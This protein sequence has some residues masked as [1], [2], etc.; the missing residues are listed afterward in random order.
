MIKNY[1]KTAFRSLMKNK[2]FTFINV[3]GLALGLATCL[4]IVFYVFDELSYDKYNLNADRIFRVDNNIKFGGDENSYAVVP[5]PTATALKNDYPEVEEV[6]RFRPRGGAKVKKGNENIQE[7]MMIYADSSIFKVFTLPMVSGDPAKAL[8]EPH[9]VVITESIAKKYFNTT[10]AAGKVLTF[11]DSSLYKVAGVIKDIPK[12]SHFN[13]DFFVSMAGRA[14]S[15]E[16]AW[17]SNNFNTYILLKPGTDY[18]K[19]EAKL[20]EFLRKHAGA[21]LQSILHLT[22]DKLEQGGNYFKFSLTPLKQIHLQSNRI[23][24]LAA[25]GNLEYVYIFSAIALFILLIACVNFMNLSTARSSNRAREVGVRKVLGSARKSLIMQFLTESVL[26]TLIST[27]IAV[28]GAWLLLPLFNQMA[29]KDL[30]VTAHIIAWL[31]PVLFVVVLVIGCLAG[32]YP[33]VFLSAFQPID[34]LKGKLASGFKGGMLRSFL[35]VFQFAIS[36]VLII[37]TLVIYNQLKFIQNTDLGYNRD[38]V[39]IINNLWT[40]NHGAKSFK[41]EVKQISGVENATLTGALPT[42]DYGNSSALFKDPVIDQKRS[43]ISQEWTVDVDYINTLGIKLKAGRNF[44]K[45]MPTDT[46]AVIINEAAA[47]MLG[48]AN[49]LNQM[50]YEPADNMVKKLNGYHIIGVIKNFN[51]KSLRNNVT[52][53]VL[54]LND[55]RGAL[56]IRIKSAN[57]PMVLSQ[58]KNLWKGR[59]PNQVLNYSF[60]DDDF[61]A[62]YRSERRT[63]K[64]AVVFTSLAILIA[65]LGLFGLA[66]Y[67]TEQRTKEIGIRK[68][69]GA[70]VSTIVGMLSKDFIL[71]VLVSIMVASP[72]AY[73][74]MYKWLQGFAYHQNIQWWI[75]AVAGIGAMLIAFVTISFQAIKAALTNPVKSLKSE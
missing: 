69:L 47:K 1:I 64:I 6:A 53:L 48:Y 3:F 67:A 14:D 41:N 29:D 60:M 71:L 37:G 57:V 7:N 75:I 56:S 61:D 28:F 35:V 15:R 8:T 5:S 51:F 22:F 59:S 24:E 32:L 39:L 58:V 23:S 44:S 21:Q 31:V 55:D 65:C 70:N 20:P 27:L 12:Q 2:G 4:L 66:A 26:I 25:N 42:A 46:T 11:N 72:F 34:V 17:F 18:K 62:L 45:D 16:D 33:A 38:H 30:T 36:I 68:V 74:F 63:G 52:P 10:N 50:I 54:L 13:Y 9:T 40:L 19:L 73:Y 43:I 49:P